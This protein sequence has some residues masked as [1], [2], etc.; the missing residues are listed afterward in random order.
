MIEIAL[1]KCTVAASK[2]IRAVENCDMPSHQSAS[3]PIMTTQTYGM[4]GVCP[5]DRGQ[6]DCEPRTRRPRIGGL[7]ADDPPGGNSRLLLAVLTGQA[8][9]R[10][11]LEILRRIAQH[12]SPLRLTGSL[13]AGPVS[14]KHVECQLESLDHSKLRRRK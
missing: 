12:G 6:H 9:Q 10:L 13:I 3:G 1:A 5:Y 2:E 8:L 14:D 4:C 11:L 7:L